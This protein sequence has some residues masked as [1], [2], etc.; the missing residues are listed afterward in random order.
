VKTAL[1][2]N[3]KMVVKRGKLHREGGPAIEHTN[4]DKEWWL[5]GKRHYEDGPAVKRA[6]GDKEWWEHGK[7]LTLPIN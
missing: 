2:K 3:P 5:R 1:L 6:N 4:G 7:R